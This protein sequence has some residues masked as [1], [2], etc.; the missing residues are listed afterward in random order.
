MKSTITYRA[1]LLIAL[2]LCHFSCRQHHTT[3]LTYGNVNTCKSNPPFLHTYGLSPPIYLDLRQRRHNGLTIIEAKPNGKTLRL[4]SW[5]DAG[6]LGGY[7][8]D[9]IGNIFVSPMPHVSLFQSPLTLENIL[10]K[11][12][13]RTGHMDSIFLFPYKKAP[14]MKNPFGITGMSFDCDTK[15]IYV[16]SIAGSDP[17]TEIGAIYQFDPQTNIILDQLSGID[18]MGLAVFNTKKDKRLYFGLARKPHIYSIGLDQNGSFVGNTR[19]EFSLSTIPGGGFDNAQHIQILNNNV[20]QITGLEFNYTL[21]A[22]SDPQRNIYRF[23]FNPKTDRWTSI[24]V[25]KE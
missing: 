1:L 25:Q 20:M 7:V 2:A 16:A 15:S 23:S 3:P 10:Y 8:S 18:V 4:P 9:H 5:D 24:G 22:A 11:I 12:D 6:T 17:N 14:H 21:M 19:F 13:A